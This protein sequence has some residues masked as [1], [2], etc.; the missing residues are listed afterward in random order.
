MKTKP[1]KY[2]KEFVVSELQDMLS[3]VTNDLGIF[4]IGQ[5]FENR[6][7]SRQRFSEW[8][9]KFA[10]DEEISDIKK[11]IEDLLE[12]RLVTGGLT[13]A[14]NPTLTIFTLKNK[15]NW[16][17]KTEQDITHSGD[18]SFINDVPRPKKD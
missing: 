6:S 17:D 5:L 13:S 4:F 14:L 7:Y 12:T 1:E 10:D 16:R 18:V 2:T 3:E 8:E 9:K 15:H 11:R